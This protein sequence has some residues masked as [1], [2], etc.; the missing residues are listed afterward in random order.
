MKSWTIGKKLMTGFGVMLALTLGL[1]WYSLHAIGRLGGA[2]AANTART[3]DLVGTVRLA[4]HETIEQAKFAQ[5]TYVVSHIKRL[6]G[7]LNSGME[8]TTCH[9][10]DGFESNGNQGTHCRVAAGHCRCK[11]KEGA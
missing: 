1:S 7:T 5:L 9:T 2:L 8:C 11:R 6:E 10:M 3:M 4:L